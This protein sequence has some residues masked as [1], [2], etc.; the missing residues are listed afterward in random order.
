MWSLHKFIYGEPK[1][2][3]ENEAFYNKVIDKL[4]LMQ[5]DINDLYA[6]IQLLERKIKASKVK[7][8]EETEENT[9][10]NIYNGF[11]AL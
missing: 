2:A 11:K 6:K 10:K 9:E 5:L 4:K 1:K 7:G 8:N 3:E